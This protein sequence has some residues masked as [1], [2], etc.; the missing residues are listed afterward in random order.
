MKYTILIVLC[1]LALGSC[2]SQHPEEYIAL[3]TSISI[4]P[5]RLVLIPEPQGIRYQVECIGITPYQTY[6]VSYDAPTSKGGFGSDS[7]STDQHC[8]MNKILYVSPKPIL[9]GLQNNETAAI[10]FTVTQSEAS[11]HQVQAQITRDGNG[12]YQLVK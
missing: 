2:T 10:V 12:R 11:E 8:E 4:A 1:L 9:R 5:L 3:P 6:N 7:F